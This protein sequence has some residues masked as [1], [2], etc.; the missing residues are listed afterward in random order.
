MRLAGKSAIV[1][2]GGR[3]IGRST[4]ELFCREGARV[5]IAERDEAAGQEVLDTVTRVGGQAIFVA[6]DVS[7]EEP[8]RQLMDH[9]IA[10]Y[11][12]IDILYNN[13]GGST[14]NDGP[15]TT[16]SNDEFWLKMRVD[17][18]GTWLG[19]RYAIPHMIDAGGGSIINATSITAL[20][21]TR[22]KDAYTCAKGAIIALTQSM[23]VE[24]A[25]HRIRVNAIAPA[26]TLTERVASRLAST[27]RTSLKPSD[28]LLGMSDPIDVAYAVLYLASDESKTTTGHVLAVDSGV[29]IS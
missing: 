12:A 15:V 8:M 28:H 26:G 18:F 23:A 25:E 22:N 20:I 3:G 1:T 6:T 13:V 10:A 7:D 17:L 9:A 29:S 27:D 21:G 4:V 16:V 24:F 5:I 14:P 11:G 19:C 2:G